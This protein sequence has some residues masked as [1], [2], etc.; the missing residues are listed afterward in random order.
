MLAGHLSDFQMEVTFLLY[1]LA[2]NR[3]LASASLVAVTLCHDSCSLDIH[4]RALAREG[5]AGVRL[6]DWSG[7]RCAPHLGDATDR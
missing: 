7:I 3:E 4:V 1:G 2:F 5:A 6:W